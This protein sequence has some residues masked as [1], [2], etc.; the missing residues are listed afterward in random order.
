MLFL[1]EPSG[2]TNILRNGDY[3]YSERFYIHENHYIEVCDIHEQSEGDY[4]ISR[5]AHAT[6]LATPPY[7][8][9]SR[10]FIK[11][12]SRIFININNI[13]Y[14][15]EIDFFCRYKIKINYGK[16]DEYADAKQNGKIFVFPSISIT[17]WINDDA[18]A[19]KFS[20]QMK[21]VMNYGSILPPED[22]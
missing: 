5:H 15:K 7:K 10:Y 8:L 21:H 12:N 17:I 13:A 2:F 3:E 19:L 14:V 20:S 18:D 9:F 1:V 11:L 4:D 16:S 6:P 22:L